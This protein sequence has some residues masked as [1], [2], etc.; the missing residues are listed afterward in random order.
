MEQTIEDSGGQDVV[1]EDV[2]PL[3]K[4]FVACKDDAA[5]LIATADELEEELG[6]HA[7]QWEVAHLVQDQEFRFAH[8]EQSVGEAILL[9]I[10][11]QHLD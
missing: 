4:G 9:G 7:V 10:L 2:A 1:S 5:S 11:V 3:A 8:S 6:Y